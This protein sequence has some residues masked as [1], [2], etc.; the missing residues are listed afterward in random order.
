MEQG[1]SHHSP[2]AG[3]ALLGTVLRSHSVHWT[4]PEAAPK[5]MWAAA[6]CLSQPHF[7]AGISHLISLLDPIFKSMKGIG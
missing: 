2:H 4:H 7:W 6:I 1:K 5:S 3:P